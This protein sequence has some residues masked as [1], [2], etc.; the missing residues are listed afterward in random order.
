MP[1][2]ITEEL[3]LEQVQRAKREEDQA[4]GSEQD[5]AEHAHERRADKADYLRE[6]LA[7]RAKAED[8]A[9]EDD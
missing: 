2:P 5:A 8:E 4:R 1:D 9:A 7:E 6:K 3:R